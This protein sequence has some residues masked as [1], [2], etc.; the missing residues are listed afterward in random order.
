[1]SVLE[2][3]ILGFVQGITEFLP[4]SSSGHLVLIHSFFGIS[5]LDLAYDAILQLATALAVCCFF[6]TDIKEI[7]RNCIKLVGGFEVEKKQKDFVLALIVGTIPGLCF[8]LLL[9]SYMESVFR[10]VHLVAG[11]LIIGSVLMFFAERF[12]SGQSSISTKNGFIIGL[13]QSLALVPGISRS[14]ASISGGMFVGLSRSDATRFS[15]LLSIPIIVGSGLKKGIE[16]ASLGTHVL[17][18]FSLWISFFVSFF[19]GLLAIRFLLR[20]LSTNTLGSFIFYRLLIAL[21]I[22]VFL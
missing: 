4:V 11:A 10:S 15:F 7:V 19:V 14:G 3:I 21:A 5:E 18:N 9:E 2:G 13:F 22:L 20:F 6:F 1:M 17:L 8:G 16:L 12:Y